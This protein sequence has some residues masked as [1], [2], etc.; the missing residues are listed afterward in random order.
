MLNLYLSQ[1]QHAFF[2]H[3]AN[4]VHQVFHRIEGLLVD[5]PLQAT[6]AHL[7]RVIDVLELVPIQRDAQQP[8]IIPD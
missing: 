7:Q 1:F 4:R 8:L 6:V 2:V 3:F 5:Q